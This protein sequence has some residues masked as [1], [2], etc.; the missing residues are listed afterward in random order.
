MSRDLPR[1]PNLVDEHELFEHDVF[2]NPSE[3][4]ERR[5]LFDIISQQAKEQ[6]DLA[7]KWAKDECMLGK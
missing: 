4:V 7:D 2:A 6:K 5:L 1:P 3:R